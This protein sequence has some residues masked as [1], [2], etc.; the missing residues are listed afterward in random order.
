MKIVQK[1]ILSAIS[2]TAV[3]GTSAMAADLSS[4]AVSGYQSAR[5]AGLVS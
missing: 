1:M 5:E 4:W 2:L 3:L